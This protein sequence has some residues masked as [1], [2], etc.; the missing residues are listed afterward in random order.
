M[1]QEVHIQHFQ[2]ISG[3]HPKKQNSVDSLDSGMFLVLEVSCMMSQKH[4][5]YPEHIT[6]PRLIH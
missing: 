6:S 5:T 2:A 3:L 1:V 4:M